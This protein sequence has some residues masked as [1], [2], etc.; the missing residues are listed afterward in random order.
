MLVK[1]YHDLVQTPTFLVP[2]S[3]KAIDL[4]WD[5]LQYFPLRTTEN[6]TLSPT[7]IAA[8]DANGEVLADGVLLDGVNGFLLTTEGRG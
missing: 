7:R 2:R 4:R 3:R 5:R 6:Y 8:E 1:F